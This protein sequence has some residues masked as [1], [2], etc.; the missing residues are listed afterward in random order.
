MVRRSFQWCV[1]VSFIGAT[2]KLQTRCGKASALCCRRQSGE[3]RDVGRFAS[4][5][6]RL[7]LTRRKTA[8]S[9]ILMVRLLLVLADGVTPTPR[10]I[11][12][13]VTQVKNAR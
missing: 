7:E 1:M 2:G 13:L 8:G 4:K 9:G 11:G 12:R 6:Q 10:K 3:E 5:G